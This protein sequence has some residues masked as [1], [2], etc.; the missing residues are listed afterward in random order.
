[1]VVPN[2]WWSFIFRRVSRCY[3]PTQK[4]QSLSEALIDYYLWTLQSRWTFSCCSKWTIWACDTSL[5]YWCNLTKVMDLETWKD[6]TIC[7][8][9]KRKD[10]TYD[11]GSYRSFALLSMAGNVL[12]HII[13]R[14]LGKLDER[15]LPDA[16]SIR[17]Q[18]RLIQSLSSNSCTN[19]HLSN[20]AWATPKT[21]FIDLGKKTTVCLNLPF[22]L[23]HEGWT[24]CK[25]SKFSVHIS[26][27]YDS[28]PRLPFWEILIAITLGRCAL[29]LELTRGTVSVVGRYRAKQSVGT[30]SKKL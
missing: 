9:P 30:L 29:A 6:A 2:C 10:D 24:Y 8:L 3:K 27:W 15:L 17:V 16:K 7:K 22:K 13:N 21:D 11:C 12:V 20:I 4:W 25:I 23:F 5:G 14:R 26:R 1:M 28:P 19:G 18:E